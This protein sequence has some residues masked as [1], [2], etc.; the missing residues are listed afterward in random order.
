MKK[1][2]YEPM[3]LDSIE[4]M[5]E[6]NKQ[7][8]PILNKAVGK[9][10]IASEWWGRNSEQA[11]HAWEV[12]EDIAAHDMSEVMSGGLVDGDECLLEEIEACEAME[13]LKQVLFIAQKAK[14]N[15]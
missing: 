8:N 10:E 11:R 13:E 3:P 15:Q 4:A 5:Q 2:K 9:A 1:T 7:R 12:V 14:K 6:K